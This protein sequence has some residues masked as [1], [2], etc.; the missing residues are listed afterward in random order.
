[1]T[2]PEAKGLLRRRG[3]SAERGF[4]D[5]KEHRGL[6]RITGRGLSRARTDVGLC[7]LI[8]NLLTLHDHTAVASKPTTAAP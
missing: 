6:R 2:T 4:A 1:M 3:Q 7:V 5:L 8:H